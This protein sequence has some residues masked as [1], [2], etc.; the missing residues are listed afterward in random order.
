MET[1]TF[2]FGDLVVGNQRAARYNIT[3]TGTEWVVVDTYPPS[4]V[5]ISPKLFHQ[6]Q[7][8]GA[9]RKEITDLKNQP[10]SVQGACFDV[11]RNLLSNKNNA[12][13]LERYDG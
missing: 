11:I 12:H 7:E 4:V 9:S 8:S 6:L 3:R 10:F 1:K 5:V 2:Q 13:V